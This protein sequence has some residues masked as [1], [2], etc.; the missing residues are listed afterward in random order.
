MS[1]AHLTPKALLIALAIIIIWGSNF[2]VIKVG[3]EAFEPLA[4]LATRFT[5]AGLLFLPFVK[6]PGLRKAAMIASIGLL[7]GLLHQGLLYIGLL[8]MPA[9]LMSIILQSNV[10]IVTLIGWL[11]L[12]EHIGWR[13][14]TGIGVALLG[15]CILVY[16]PDQMSGATTIGYLYGFASALFIAFAYLMMKKINQVHAPTYMVFL[17]LPIAPFMILASF[18]FEGTQWT[19]NIEG[20][21]WTII[22]FAVLYQSVILSLSHIAWQKLVVKYAMSQLVPLTLAI[23]IFAILASWL[24]LNEEITPIIILG[25][26]LTIFGISIVTFRKIKKGVV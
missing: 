25:G 1:Q 9:G 19:Q 15:I 18:L 10:I 21:N 5:L 3:A 13:T 4:F 26:G 24:F 17:H 12:K 20:M 22:G 11:F 23:P 16:K 2:V 7:M 14:W 8:H 6:W